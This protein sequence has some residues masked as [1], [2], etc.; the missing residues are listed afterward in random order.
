VVHFLAIDAL[1]VVIWSGAYMGVGYL[2]TGQLERALGYVQRMGSGFGIVVLT[3]FAAWIL[4]KFCERRRI[5]KQLDVARIAPEELRDRITAGEALYVVDLR[6]GPKDDSISIPG[7]IR[8][9]T[10]DLILESKRI[11][12]DKEIILVCS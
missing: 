3:L 12:R 4:W 10:E 6:G 7:V 1:G 8:L 2:F 9:S 5:L 11:P